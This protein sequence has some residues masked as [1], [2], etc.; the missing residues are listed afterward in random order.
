MQKKGK[1]KDTLKHNQ[2]RILHIINLL[3]FR[4][5]KATSSSMMSQAFPTLLRQGSLFALLSM[6]SFSWRASLALRS[7]P[8]KAATDSS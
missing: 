3:R 6:E 1:G 8:T 4:R 5:R 2:V 7:V